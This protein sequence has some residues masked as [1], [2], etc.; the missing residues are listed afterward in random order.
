MARAD[1]G[2]QQRSGV[3]GPT[4]TDHKTAN[5]AKRKHR[6]RHRFRLNIARNETRSP[7]SNRF[8]N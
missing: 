4:S 2:P 1:R 3:D 7:K 6:G 8:A 5:I